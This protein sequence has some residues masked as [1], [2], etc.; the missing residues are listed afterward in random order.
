MDTRELR[1]EPRFAVNDPVRLT[2]VGQNG[3]PRVE[4]RVSS[5]SRSGL[6]IV[7]PLRIP[8]G[9]DVIVEMSGMVVSGRIR[10]ATKDGE[11]Y[12]TGLKIEAVTK[13]AESAKHE[14]QS[15]RAESLWG[16][17]KRLDT[18]VKGNQR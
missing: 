3:Y 7:I 10:Y 9:T 12:R 5:L 17:L 18:A 8:A 2:V 16:T 1:L 13:A 14:L 11:A 15:P 4:G 6:S